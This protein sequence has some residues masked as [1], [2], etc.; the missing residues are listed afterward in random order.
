MVKQEAASPSR[1]DPEDGAFTESDVGRDAR[2]QA[3][4]NHDEAQVLLVYMLQTLFYMW[5]N[6]F[7]KFRTNSIAEITMA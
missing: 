2:G 6:K 3:P 4:P 7:L 1:S 5:I